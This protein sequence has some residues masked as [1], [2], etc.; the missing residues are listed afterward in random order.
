MQLVPR[1]Q[2]APGSIHQ[3]CIPVVWAVMRS[4]ASDRNGM[5]LR[6]VIT[7][8]G[9]FDEADTTYL[10]EPWVE[11]STAVVAREPDGGGLPPEAK[12]LGLSYFI[13]VEIAR[14]FLDDWIATLPDSPT[15][16][17]RCERLIQYAINDA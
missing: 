10:S 9:A 3:R 12:A 16:G 2:H 13:E 8:L 17:E 6:D 7:K 4:G 15:V 14:N 1:S 11:G 5:T